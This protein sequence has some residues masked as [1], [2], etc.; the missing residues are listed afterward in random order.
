MHQATCTIPT[1]LLHCW[2]VMSLPSLLTV[3]NKQRNRLHS[4]THCTVER[5]FGLLKLHYDMAKVRDMGLSRM[6]RKGNCW[7]NTLAERCFGSLK[8][9]RGG[10]QPR[11]KAQQDVMNYITM[12]YN[13]LGLYSYVGYNSPNQF[14]S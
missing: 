2:I 11:N 14:R 3:Q 13:S 9:E 7:D 8:Q 10:N 1:V 6:S 5:D 12:W 4:G